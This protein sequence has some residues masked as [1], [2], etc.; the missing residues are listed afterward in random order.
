MPKRPSSTQENILAGA[1]SLIGVPYVTADT[2]E[3]RIDKL[4]KK[5]MI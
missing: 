3:E 1:C 5:N 4:I 2:E